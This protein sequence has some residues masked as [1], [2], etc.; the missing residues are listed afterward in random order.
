MRPPATSAG[1]AAR[2]GNGRSCGGYSRSPGWTSGREPVIAVVAG[3]TARRGRGTRG[4]C[5]CA[6][7]DDAM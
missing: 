3:W 2:P 6:G 7:H 5:L 4:G 1:N